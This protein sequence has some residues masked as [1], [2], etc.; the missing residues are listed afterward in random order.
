MDY[1]RKPQEVANLGQQ[2]DTVAFRLLRVKDLQ[3]E[4]AREVQS[5]LQRRRMRDVLVGRY[6]I[7]E[8]LAEV[9][10]RQVTRVGLAVDGRQ[11]TRG[12]IAAARGVEGR[13][14]TRRAIAAER[15]QATSVGRQVTRGVFAG[16]WPAGEV[17]AEVEGLGWVPWGVS[18]LGQAIMDAPE[19]E[20]VPFAEVLGDQSLMGC[21]YLPHKQNVESLVC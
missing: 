9:E 19:V 5:F 17:L 11:V 10:G 21:R 13:Q 2:N 6:V 8:L 16:R 3:F 1:Y 15:R 4:L 18:E 12:A 20:L 14:V 7:W